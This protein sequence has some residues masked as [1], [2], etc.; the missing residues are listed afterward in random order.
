MPTPYQRDGQSTGSDQ[1]FE[2]SELGRKFLTKT[3]KENHKRG[4]WPVASTD[5]VHIGR[6][7]AGTEAYDHRHVGGQEFAIGDRF[8]EPY[9]GIEVRSAGDVTIVTAAE[10]ET[11][12]TFTADET[13]EIKEVSVERVVSTTIGTDSDIILYR[14]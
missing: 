11:T 6:P 5:T 7:G 10:E 4:P 1:E 14:F 12:L 8:G 13:G 3:L 2:P 9:H